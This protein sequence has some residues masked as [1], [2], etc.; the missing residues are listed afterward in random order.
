VASKS[1][2]AMAPSLLLRMTRRENPGSLINQPLLLLAPGDIRKSD[3]TL[4]LVVQAVERVRH[5]ADA[6]DIG[7][8]DLTLVL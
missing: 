6:D 1:T 3:V 5:V 7:K 2:L 8:N 4:M